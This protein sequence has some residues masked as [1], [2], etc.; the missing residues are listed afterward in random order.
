MTCWIV[1]FNKEPP[2]TAVDWSRGGLGIVSFGK[3]PFDSSTGALATCSTVFGGKER[4]VAVVEAWH[5]SK[6]KLVN[7]IAR[8]LAP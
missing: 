3:D 4:C 8:T 2:F 7:Q 1:S 5:P 6:K